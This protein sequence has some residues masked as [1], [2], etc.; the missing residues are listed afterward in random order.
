M[1]EPVCDWCALDMSRRCPG[2]AAH[3]AQGEHCIDTVEVCAL[4][5]RGGE[6]PAGHPHR[7]EDCGAELKVGV[8]R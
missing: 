8:A 5:W 4:E 1:A 7:C 6:N 3:C 2:I